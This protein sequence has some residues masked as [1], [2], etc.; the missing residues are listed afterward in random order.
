VTPLQKVAMGLVLVVVDAFFYGYDAIPDPLGW[1]LVVFGVLQLRDLLRGS[2]TLL[3]VAGLAAVVSL[4]VYPPQIGD[5]VTPSMG[6]LLSLPQ[7]AFT[8]LLCRALADGGTR[9][10]DPDARRFGVLR[11]VFLALAAL[12]A[13]VFGG[14]VAVLAG[15]TLIASV[16]AAVYLIY[17]LFKVSKRPW[18]GAPAQPSRGRV[19]PGE[20][21]PGKPPGSG[22]E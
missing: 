7:L 18:T 11:W 3:G 17:L 6:W 22:Q 10:G 4:V 9:A 13:L 5:A 8:F 2:G 16:L 19:T 12:P 20:Q 21:S 15:P 1:L 14:R